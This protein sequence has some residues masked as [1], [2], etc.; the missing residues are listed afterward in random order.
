MLWANVLPGIIVSSYLSALVAVVMLSL[1]NTVI[2]PILVLLTLPLTVFTLGLFLIVLN[3]LMIG[4][5]AYLTPGFQVQGFLSILIFGLLL[6]LSNAVI[7]K[8]TEK[9][10]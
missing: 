6:G 5:A 10:D 1:V 9:N 7:D 4:L 3:V 2:R 8:L